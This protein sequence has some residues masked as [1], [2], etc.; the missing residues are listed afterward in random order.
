LK[1]R[2]CKTGVGKIVIAVDTSGSI[3]ERELAQFAG[4][5]SPICNEAKPVN[6]PVFVD[7]IFREDRNRLGFSS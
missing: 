4:E 5:I 7:S 2:V 1:K 3:G 6:N